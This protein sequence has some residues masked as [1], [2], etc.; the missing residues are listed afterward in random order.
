MKRDVFVE[1]SQV[2]ALREAVGTAL[3]AGEGY[4]AMV[5]AYGEAGTGKT[6]AAR[7]LYSEYLGFYV[8]VM[9]GMTQAAFL[10]E[11][12]FEITGSRPH[13]SMR[14]KS[15]INSALRN[16]PAPLF[17]DEA[18]RLQKPRLEDLRDIHDATGSPVI[19][20]GEMGLPTVVSARSRI[21]DRIPDAFRVLF[22][23]ISRAD[24]HM[25]AAK[26]AGL[27]LSPEAGQAVLE[28]TKGNFRRVHNAILS[29]E[30]AARAKGTAEIDA[31]LAR[32][33]LGGKKQ[34]GAR[35]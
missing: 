16:E 35:A 33:A 17:I 19:L 8:R 29:I 13:G 21:N 26:A 28:S 34:R 23:E 9:E 6:R 15:A 1:T 14:C 25:Y 22:G 31:E 7:S 27:N 12:C 24:V 32:A 3:E 18:D 20:I 2:A 5:M 11:I 10:Q 4:P 30:G